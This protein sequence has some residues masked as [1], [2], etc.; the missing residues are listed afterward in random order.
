MVASRESN[1]RFPMSCMT[2][3]AADTL[4]F[5]CCFKVVPVAA[6]VHRGV[7]KSWRSLPTPQQVKSVYM[8]FPP[9]LRTML[10]VFVIFMGPFMEVVKRLLGAPAWTWIRGLHHLLM[11]TVLSFW[12]LV[13]GHYLWCVYD[14]NNEQGTERV[15]L[16]DSI[17]LY[18]VVLN[19]DVINRLV[20]HSVFWL[21]RGLID[22]RS[23]LVKSFLQWKVRRSPRIQRTCHP[24]NR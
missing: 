2:M 23:V 22:W 14:G 10:I 24:R 4:S 5:R 19:D 7:E 3:R 15:T 6:D 12:S 11:Y 13:V 20:C 18:N 9:F 16:K 8:S 17:G 21:L 1:P